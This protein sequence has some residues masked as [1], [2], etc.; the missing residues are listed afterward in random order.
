MCFT[1]QFA[2]A[3]LTIPSPAQNRFIQVPSYPAGGSLPTLLAQHDVNGDGK[4]D[5][6]VLNVNTTA[7]TE[8]VSLLLGTGTGGYEAPKTMATYPSSYGVPLAGDVNGDGHLDLIFSVSGTSPQT[9]VYLGTGDTFETTA[10]VSHRRELRLHFLRVGCEMQLAD[11]NKDGKAD[12]IEDS[13]VRTA[14]R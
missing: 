2:L 14:A 3:F 4:L 11:L 5:L 10:K 7:K 6:I 9:R 12:L 1:A 8:T 13:L